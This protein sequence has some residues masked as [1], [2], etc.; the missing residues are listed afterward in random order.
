[1][2]FAILPFGTANNIA[3]SIGYD[4]P[5]DALVRRWD[6][7]RL[8]PFDL[9]LARGSWGDKRFLEGVG[10]RLIPDF[11]RT[12]NDL[13]EEKGEQEADA[14]LEV[15]RRVF[16]ETVALLKPQR[17]QLTADGERLDGDFL[18]VEILNIRSIGPQLRLMP[19]AD[20]SDGMLDLVT[21]GEDGR[22]E[23]LEL[24]ESGPDEN[25]PALPTRRVRCVELLNWRGLHIDDQLEDS[26]AGAV[27]VAVEPGKI[28][29]LV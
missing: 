15:A 13:L 22:D 7:A 11:M 21:A 20:P 27:S 25:V 1:L 18:L 14:E 6:G 8:V 2:P 12:A 4:G 29:F 24:L 3:R 16:R 9:G 19:D 23:L 10:I 28:R 17:C 5:S 26:E